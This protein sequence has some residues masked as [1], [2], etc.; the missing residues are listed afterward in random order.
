MGDLVHFG[1]AR[2]LAREEDFA[3]ADSRDNRVIIRV[4]DDIIGARRSGLS[5]LVLISSAAASYTDNAAIAKSETKRDR[6][7]HSLR[8]WN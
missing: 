7:K 5:V 4:P 2:T 1:L 3:L 6:L 8:I